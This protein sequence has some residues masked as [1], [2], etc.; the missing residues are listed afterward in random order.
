MGFLGFLTENFLHAAPILL[1]GGFALAIIVERMIA[2]TKTYPMPNAEGFLERLE[3]LVSAGK[4]DQAAALCEKNSQKPLAQVARAALSRAHLP[5]ALIEDG[6]SLEIAAAS[7]QVHKRTAYLSTIANVATLLGLF[8]TIAGLIASFE[9]VGHADP[10]QKSALLSAGIATA[11]NATMLGLGVA[12]PCM[13]A[14]S[15]LMSRAN[16]IVSELEHGGLRVID[17]LK[18][19]FYAV[20]L[21]EISEQTKI[22]NGKEKSKWSQTTTARDKAA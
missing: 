7:N 15:F 17:I 8:G 22:E 10:Q 21:P 3:E 18:R 19:R 9:A 4:L 1:A 6:I 11:M 13:V 14:F 5:D 2:L 16:R 20:E 12:I